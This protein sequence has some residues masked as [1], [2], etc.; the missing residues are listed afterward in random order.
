MQFNLWLYH[1]I[2]ASVHPTYWT[3]QFALFCSNILL[4]SFIILTIF[5]HRKNKYFIFIFLAT[6][7][8]A[9][10]FSEILN[11]FLYFPRPF[12][13]H[14]G[15]TLIHHAPTSSLPS[16]HMLIISSLCCCLFFKKDKFWIPVAVII[17]ICVGWS[18]IYLGVH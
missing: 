10:L 12:I 17:C 7:A 15:H 16:H 1:F 2:N 14:I 5:F 4:P 13:L 9:I 8:I 11:H 18:R 3:I 6:V